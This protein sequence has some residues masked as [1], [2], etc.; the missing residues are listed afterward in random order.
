MC[1]CVCTCV[2]TALVPSM[3]L[4][5]AGH[6]ELVRT[7]S[8]GSGN[9]GC[10]GERGFRS[11]S[12]LKELLLMGHCGGQGC[13]SSFPLPPQKPYLGSSPCPLGLP[14]QG[15]TK[16]HRP[17]EQRPQHTHRWTA[18]LND[19]GSRPPVALGEPEPRSFGC[20]YQVCIYA[21]VY[22]HVC[23]QVCCV[24]VCMCVCK[25]VHMEGC[26]CCMCI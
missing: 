23:I 15:R 5:A 4:R 14:P 17:R 12:S 20:V 8:H 21:N 19:P 10:G 11:W 16:H 3:D 9:W 18:G 1:V 7:G 26:V 13:Q 24:Q 6:S 22:I 25:C 2:C